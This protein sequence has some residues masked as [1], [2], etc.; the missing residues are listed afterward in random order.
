MSIRLMSAVWE[1]ELPHPEML[2][3]LALADHGD[4]DGAGIFPSQGRIA[5][6]SGYSSRRV[7]T[8]LHKLETLGLIVKVSE[9]VGH[10]G[11]EYRMVVSAVPHKPPYDPKGGRNFR[12]EET[13]GRKSA[14]AQGGN[15]F[16]SSP[17]ETSAKPSVEP[18][19]ET[20]S[21]GDEASPH[22]PE[23]RAKPEP[24]GDVQGTIAFIF[25]DWRIKTGR[26]LKVRL[27]EARAKAI[28]GRLVRDHF[29]VED[30]QRANDGAA[31]ALADEVLD[32]PSWATEVYRIHMDRE[33][34]LAWISYANNGDSD[35]LTELWISEEPKEAA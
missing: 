11:T 9:A 26:S 16:L 20:K 13:S 29:A 32:F 33:H 1:L 6:K 30:L 10:R 14:T 22:P 23:V 34:V 21:L 3:A 12:A 4:D 35:V 18:S 31:Q 2:V 28:G 27:T 19:V 7:R 25:E 5:W 8:I 15:P 17:E 24:A